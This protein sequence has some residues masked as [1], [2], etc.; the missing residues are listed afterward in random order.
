MV[1]EP[2]FL[3]T[4]QLRIKR[5]NLLSK[6]VTSTRTVLSAS[7]LIACLHFSLT[8]QDAKAE[9]DQSQIEVNKNI[10]TATAS[11]EFEKLRLERFKV[12]KEII[13]VAITVVF[14]TALGVLINN[15]FQNRQLKQQEVLRNAELKLQ[16]N[17]EKAELNLQNAKA[18][19]ERR[20]AEM[21]YL[22]DFITYALADDHEKRLRFAD[23]FA[24]LTI[25]ADLQKR[26]ETYRC[27]I[28]DT[29]KELEKTKG[30]LAEAQ[31]EGGKDEDE[32]RKLEAEV[33]R[34]QA[35][36]SPLP[37]KS[38]AYLTYEKTQS[39]LLDENLKPK[40]YT[41]NEFEVQK[42]GKVIYDKATGLMWQQSGSEKNMTY[43]KAHNYIRQLNQKGF[44][45]YSDWRLPTLKEAITLLKPG[46]TDKGLYVDSLFNDEQKWVWTSDLSS[47]SSA[48]V[49]GFGTG[50]CGYGVFGLDSYVRAVR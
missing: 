39:F 28:I 13:T 37:E 47:A 29:I 31:K 20:Q 34:L 50:Y 9:A 6:I 48:W 23:Y 19:A 45:S 21:K 14:G 38:G 24:K 16:E 36:L 2:V 46:K 22:G 25:S 11:L 18:E 32:V 3:E 17:K 43:N 42:D 4:V 30:E 40:N 33:V 26:W 5:L 41:K 1:N 8:L 15:K 35:Q 12:W 44:A 49:V 27:G 10:A 7:I